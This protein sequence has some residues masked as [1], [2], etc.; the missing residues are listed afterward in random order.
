[1]QVCTAI[2]STR[3]CAGF[4]AR[5][6]AYAAARPAQP[7]AHGSRRPAAHLFQ[8]ALDGIVEQQAVL[9]GG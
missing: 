6:A 3:M 4:V 7:Q 2:L 1:M 8:D 9:V 5:Y